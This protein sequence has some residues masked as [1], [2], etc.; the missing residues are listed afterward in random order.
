M[1]EAVVRCTEG[2]GIWQWASN[3][4]ILIVVTSGRI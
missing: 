1:D 4:I 2:I 3:D